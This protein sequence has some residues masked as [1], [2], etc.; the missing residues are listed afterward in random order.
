MPNREEMKN[1][2]DIENYLEVVREAIDRLYH[3]AIVGE[4]QGSIKH[5]QADIDS[6]IAFAYLKCFQDELEKN[7]G[8]DK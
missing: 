1:H 2:T 3:S 7:Q 4:Y 8:H 6:T 5:R